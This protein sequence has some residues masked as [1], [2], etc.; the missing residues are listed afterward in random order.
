[1]MSVM[2]QPAHQPALNPAHLPL[3][4]D[5]HEP[6]DVQLNELGDLQD[7]LEPF[8]QLIRKSGHSVRLHCTIPTACSSSAS[9]D[10]HDL[11]DLR[12]RSLLFVHNLIETLRASGIPASYRLQPSNSH[13]CVICALPMGLD[14]N[15]M[16]AAA[17]AAVE[18]ARFE[19]RSEKALLA[20]LQ[21]GL[22]LIIT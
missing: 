7:A 2:P 11:H 3:H 6:Q 13:L 12:T 18:N 19:C 1:M 14:A 21:D 15:R 10:L 8:A 17:V 5:S 20:D 9:Y 4:V 16:K 22:A